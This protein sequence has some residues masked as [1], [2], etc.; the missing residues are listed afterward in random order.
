MDAKKVVIG[1]I[2]IIAAVLGIRQL[3]KAQ[4]TSPTPSPTPTIV[5]VTV[6][7]TAYGP[8][9]KYWVAMPAS[10]GN[11][12]AVPITEPIVWLNI[13]ADDMIFPKLSI[14]DMFDEDPTYGTGKSLRGQEGYPNLAIGLSA[15]RALKDGEILTWVSSPNGWWRDE[16]GQWV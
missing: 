16:S 10:I 7:A 11:M 3:V 2:V 1:S 14:V 4:P 5:S 6:K 13:P 8:L 9:A 12:I 15:V